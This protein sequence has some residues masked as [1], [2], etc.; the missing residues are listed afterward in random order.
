MPRRWSGWPDTWSAWVKNRKEITAK[1]LLALFHSMNQE[2]KTSFGLEVIFDETWP[3]GRLC[4]MWFGEKLIWQ[5]AFDAY[6]NPAS[7]SSEETKA[8][9]IRQIHTLLDRVYDAATVGDYPS[10]K[11]LLMNEELKRMADIF[12]EEF[13]RRSRPVRNTQRDA[14]I[15]QLHDKE[16]VSFGGIGKRLVVMNSVWAGKNGKPLSRMAAEKAYHRYKSANTDK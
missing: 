11:G 8:K 5:M 4:C 2:E 1:D 13:R 10:V 9:A 16:G 6:L 15:V 3:V 14:A 7:H 12:R